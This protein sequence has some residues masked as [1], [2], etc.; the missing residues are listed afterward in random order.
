MNWSTPKC[1]LIAQGCHDTWRSRVR[2]CVHSA[3]ACPYGGGK[4]MSA[5]SCVSVSVS[6][7]NRLGLCMTLR[8]ALQPS[9][10]ETDPFGVLISGRNLLPSVSSSLCI[11]PCCQKQGR[12]AH[13]YGMQ[14]KTMKKRER[15][16]ETCL[17]T[18]KSVPHYAI[19]PHIIQ[20]SFTLFQKV[21][22]N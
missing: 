18:F 11:L 6:P 20:F 8:I 3:E 1:V 16:R 21:F 5:I 10:C 4:Q 9:G 2:W 13:V 17:N 15:E 22:H 14:G 7:R 19:S 12:H